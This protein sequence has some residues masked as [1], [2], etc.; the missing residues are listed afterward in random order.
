[1][2]SIHRGTAYTGVFALA[3]AGLAFT[4]AFTGLAGAAMADC[5]ADLEALEAE[6]AYG[7]VDPALRDKAESMIDEAR[8]MLQQGKEAECGDM[9]AGIR[10]SLGLN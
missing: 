1:M 3:L 2:T 8:T 10:A 4:L 5:A 6:I 9:A 7:N